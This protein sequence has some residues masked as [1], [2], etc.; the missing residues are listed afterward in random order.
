MQMTYLLIEFQKFQ[1]MH[2]LI[3]ILIKVDNLTRITLIEASVELQYGEILCLID[4][5]DKW[6]QRRDEE[7][8]SGKRDMHERRRQEGVRHCILKSPFARHRGSVRVYCKV[9]IVFIL[10][11]Y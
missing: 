4:A 1:E 11:I 5:I 10:Y 8:R 6:S 7:Y 2:L 3:W 9:I